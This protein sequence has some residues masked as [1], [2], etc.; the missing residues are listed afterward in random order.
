MGTL[1]KHYWQLELSNYIAFGDPPRLEK[2]TVLCNSQN[3]CKQLIG[4]SHV[5]R[6]TQDCTHFYRWESK[7]CILKKPRIAVW[8]G[9]GVK[10]DNFFNVS[11]FS[12][13]I[14]WLL[15][16]CVANISSRSFHT[17]FPLSGV[18][19][20]G[21]ATHGLQN[22]WIWP[23]KLGLEQDSGAGVLPTLHCAAARWQ[24]VVLCYT[25]ACWQGEA[26]VVVAGS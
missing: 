3:C 20:Q 5:H 8:Q 11:H 6:S 10:S 25:A 24:G 23:A 21:S 19:A 17:H 15:K 2:C 13:R 14:L 26:M 18:L 22:H 1:K 12:G 9:E 16:Q 4:K 7:L